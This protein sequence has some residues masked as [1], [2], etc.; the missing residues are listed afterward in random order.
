MPYM[1]FTNNELSD[2]LMF[3]EKKFKHS[4]IW[5][6]RAQLESSDSEKEILQNETV[7]AMKLSKNQT[8]IQEIV[9]K[10]FHFWKQFS[11]IYFQST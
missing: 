4:K 9:L 11:D 6:M 1:L 10:Y 3:N 7:A 5:S 2:N 8:I